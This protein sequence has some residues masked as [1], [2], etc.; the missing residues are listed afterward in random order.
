M[1]SA[2]ERI[3]D[4][5][6]P[7]DA[8]V[9][10]PLNSFALKLKR[11]YADAM[12][13]RFPDSLHA[14]TLAARLHMAGGETDT[15]RTLADEVY[16]LFLKQEQV[17]LPD[18][19]IL[20]DLN[21]VYADASAARKEWIETLNEDRTLLGDSLPR[22][23]LQAVLLDGA[24]RSDEA[25]SLLAG[26]WKRGVRELTVFRSLEEL[27][28]RCGRL[29]EF[30]ELL[31]EYAPKDNV[32]QVLYARRLVF[33]LRTSGRGAEARAYLSALPPVLMKRERLL[34]DS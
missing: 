34:L 11:H 5:L 24:G 21:C 31:L 19:R 7:R 14:L 30:R 6:K 18:V 16:D 32:V 12:L 3:G 10:W 15:A 17:K 9:D 1:S 23:L 22:D 33:L 8:S 20:R 25:F 27:A 26:V 28:P 29:N 4:S 13:K 2:L